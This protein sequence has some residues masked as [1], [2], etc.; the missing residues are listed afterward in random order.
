MA[1]RGYKSKRLIRNCKNDK[2]H[3]APGYISRDE[4]F[5][6]YGY[7]II[8]CNI[9]SYKP[10]PSKSRVTTAISARLA[11]SATRLKSF[12]NGAV[13]VGPVVGCEVAFD[14]FN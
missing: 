11:A 13:A 4:R 3:V 7:N 9:G 10:I 5:K 2:S 1:D 8:S 12:R 14:V 6:N